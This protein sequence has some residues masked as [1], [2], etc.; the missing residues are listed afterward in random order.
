VLA[1]VD[2]DVTVYDGEDLAEYVID[3]NS[4]RR[5]MTTGAR[6]MATALVLVEDGRR[7]NGRWGYGR[8]RENPGSGELSDKNWFERLRE[9]GVIIDFLPELA[10]QVVNGEKPLDYAYQR[11][12]ERRD[13]ERH[14][15][16]REQREAREEADAKT[17][18]SED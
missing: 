7:E 6:A 11:A 13:Q 9:C 15:L 10:E 1:G 4:S 18:H 16:E 5:H 17:L 14:R 12:K 3:A 2:P 8:L